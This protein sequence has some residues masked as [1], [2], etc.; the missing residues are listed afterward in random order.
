MALSQSSIK[1]SLFKAGRTRMNPFPETIE[2]DCLF[3]IAF[4]TNLFRKRMGWIAA[5]TD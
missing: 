4:G 2:D 3:P 1:I 5:C